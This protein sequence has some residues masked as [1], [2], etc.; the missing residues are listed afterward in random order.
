M[1][2]SG[3]THFSSAIELEEAKRDVMKRWIIALAGLVCLLGPGSVYSFSLISGPLS[4]AFGWS[5][6]DVTWAFALA[7][8]FLAVG[9]LIGGIVSDR[10]GPRYVAIVGSA[11]WSLGYFLC[12][13]L[14]G[15]HSLILLYIY[16]G[17]IGGLGCG[18]AYI[19]VLNA[20]VRWFPEARGFGGGL[21]I[22]GFGLGSFVYSTLVKQWA[23]FTSVATASS[24]YAK[25]LA[26]AT[27]AHTAF[28]AA[29]HVLDPP[30]L[31][32]LMQIFLTSALAFAVVGIATAFVLQHPPEAEARYAPV[33]PQFTLRQTL[34]DARFYV[35]WAML[36]LNVFG[37]VT[38]IS[39][40]VPLMH[41]TTGMDTAAAAGAYALLAVFNGIGRFAWG[42]LSDR[43]SRRVTFALLFGGQAIAFFVLDGSKDPLVVSIAIAILLLCYGGGFGVMPAF[44]ADFFGTKHFGANYG[45][46]ITAW[47]SAAIFGTYFISTM[48]ALS[49]SYVGLMQPVS[50]VVLV[51][52]FFPLIIE[53]PKKHAVATEAPA[54]A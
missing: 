26:E 16:Y 2:R 49:G 50:L 28:N 34:A 35:I 40:M 38:M 37:G 41:E 18:A 31:A 42:W 54:G 36:F 1:A 5:G 30:H 9:G 22:M 43:I 52:M 3:R 6:S 46:Q 11:L 4:A 51:A 29:A 27:A 32:Q 7:N 10:I 23:T 8:F 25:A 13:T 17:V 45:A 21:V 39:N 19:A 47:G 12:G 48:K 33:G 14:A 24:A 53:T 20:V 44:N 15:G